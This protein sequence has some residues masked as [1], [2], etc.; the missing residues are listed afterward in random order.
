M[1]IKFFDIVQFNTSTTSTTSPLLVGTAVSGWK[2]PAQAGAVTGDITDYT[3][4]DGANTEHGWGLYT[5]GGSPSLT[6]NVIAST[7]SDALISLSGSAKVFFTAGRR[8]LWSLDAF[9]PTVAV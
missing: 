2:T 3:I 7:N 1:G 4:T 6:R 9:T 5:G 8:S